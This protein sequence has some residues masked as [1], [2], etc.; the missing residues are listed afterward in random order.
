MALK[1]DR[2]LKSILLSGIKCRLQQVQFNDGGIPFQYHALVQDQ[3]DIGWYNI[4]LAQFATQWAQCQSLFLQLL[5]TPIKFL[6]GNK[7]VSAICTVITK[8][9]LELWELRNKDHHGADSTLKSLAL[10]AQA[11][12]E[13]TILY[14]YQNTVLQ[15]DQSIFTP[16]LHKLSAGNTNQIQQWINTHQA[17]I[18]KSA[19]AAKTNAVLNVWTINTYFPIQGH[20][21]R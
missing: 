21:N 3:Q 19:K 13:I 6:S 7:W 9:W 14:S 18:L 15:K 11:V 16:N 5:P 17:V 4:F 20:I 1:T 12:Q 8:A 10:H 2:I